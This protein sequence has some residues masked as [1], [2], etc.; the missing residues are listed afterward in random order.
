MIMKTLK[1]PNR[2]K[3]IINN[4]A[5]K[6]FQNFGREKNELYLCFSDLT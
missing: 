1:V 5:G 4:A 3:C 6:L 2:K